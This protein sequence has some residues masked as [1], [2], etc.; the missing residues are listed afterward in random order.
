MNL[1]T[2]LTFILLLIINLRIL[3]YQLLIKILLVNF[4]F[5]IIKKV[6]KINYLNSIHFNLY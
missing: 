5:K 6:L 4:K 1:T 3:I 2:T